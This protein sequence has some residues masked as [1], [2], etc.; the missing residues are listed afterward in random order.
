MLEF[1]MTKLLTR[2]LTGKLNRLYEIFIPSFLRDNY[3]FAYLVFR[4]VLGKHT[5][6]YFAFKQKAKSMK[7]I[8][9]I[10]VYQRLAHSFVKRETDLNSGSIEQISLDY[11][12]NKILDAG[13]GNCYLLKI[14]AKN[15]PSLK[16][17]GVDILA[18][19]KENGISLFS[20]SIEDLPF[21]SASFDT[22]ICTHTL[23]HVLNFDKALKELRRITKKRLIIIIPRQRRSKFTPDLHLHFFPDKATL[24]KNLNSQS[25]QCKIIDNDWYYLEDIN[26]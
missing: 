16:L 25:A 26:S 20:A 5:K 14:I 2:N 3:L 4:P 8:D 17:V 10:K 13:C 18:S 9:F 11:I 1:F 15:N 22:V 23:E 21:P 6:E 7:Q 12:G 19:Q 24:L